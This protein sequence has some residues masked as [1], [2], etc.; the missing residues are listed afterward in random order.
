L[1]LRDELT[2]WLRSLERHGHEQDRAFYLEAWNGEG[3]FTFDRI[4]RG[5]T[6][7]KN[8]TISLLGTIQPSMIEPYYR[9]A[10]NGVGDDGLIQRF[11]L[12]AYP[13]IVKNYKYIDRAPLGRDHARESFK[14]LY[15]F[16]SSEV[17]ARYL[18]ADAGGYAF[19]Q[20]DDEA[21][22]IFQEWLTELET[23][24]RS[25]RI[26]N[27]A[28]ESHTAKY[29]SLVPSLALIFHLLK[30][31]TGKID[32]P[33]IDRDST[34]LAAAWCSYLQKHAE[35]LYTQVSLSEFDCAKEIL[36]R[37]QAG[38]VDEE[39]TARDIYGKHWKRLSKPEDVKR[40]LE[41]LAEFRY[42]TSVQLDTGGRGKT[43]YRCHDSIRP[44]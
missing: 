11:Q 42:L 16:R 35:K 6:H 36:K 29:R 19:L 33:L 17:D 25:G 40:G 28:L 38:E 32:A 5:K 30:R 3:S 27:P 26:E 43:I 9:S 10:M 12:L 34:L 2:G 23:E 14:R 31:V 1:V 22:E 8:L 24:L 7:I 44:K 21:Q 13:D 39:F 37:L 20:F 41:L 18:T 4:G 15:E